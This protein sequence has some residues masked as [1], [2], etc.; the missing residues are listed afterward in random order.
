MLKKVAAYGMMLLQEGL[1]K[2]TLPRF[3]AHQA[4]QL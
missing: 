4:M 3:D 1:H 2:L